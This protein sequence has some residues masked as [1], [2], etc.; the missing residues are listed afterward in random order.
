MSPSGRLDLTT[1]TFERASSTSSLDSTWDEPHNHS[2][3]SLDEIPTETITFLSEA[4]SSRQFSAAD[5]L[6]ANLQ[7]GAP[8][9]SGSPKSDLTPALNTARWVQTGSM[10]PATATREPE[11]RLGARL[12]AQQL[13]G[14]QDSMRQASVLG[15]IFKG[16]RAGKSSSPSG[17]T[18]VDGRPVARPIALHTAT[19]VS[20]SAQQQ[21][22]RAVSRSW[23]PPPSIK[24]Q[25]RAEAAL[26]ALHRRNPPAARDRK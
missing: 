17:V 4:P 12:S 19:A 10:M 20:V 7:G 24:P 8:A 21:Q 1:S 25:T 5:L 26:A 14:P 2:N 11:L 23:L 16:S 3:R 9:T 13:E 22:E 18:N 15:S 6:R